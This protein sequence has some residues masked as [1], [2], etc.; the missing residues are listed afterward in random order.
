MNNDSAHALN[1]D[2]E[3]H[4]QRMLEA[5]ERAWNAGDGSAWSADFSEDADFVNILGQLFEGRA[6]IAERHRQVLAGPFSGSQCVIKVRR[7]GALTAN[8]LVIETVH[9]VRGFPA[10]P[11]GVRAT[12]VGLL[13]TRMKYLAV[14]RND[15]WQ[16]VAA[17]NTAIS[18]DGPAGVAR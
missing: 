18:P 3:Q 17:Q 1:S 7:I 8:V 13:Q 9:E 16:F 11:P 4:C 6:A 14:R 2:D 15:R 12:S 10:L 5:Q